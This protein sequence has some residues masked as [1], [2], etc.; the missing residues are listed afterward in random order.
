MLVSKTPEIVQN[1]Y[2]SVDNWK[3]EHRE[4][5]NTGESDLVETFEGLVPIDKTEEHKYLGV[6]ISS[7]CN[8]MINAMTLCAR[9]PY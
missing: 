4:N 2:L 1:S 5:L 9:H 8:N 7:K 6:V 3:T